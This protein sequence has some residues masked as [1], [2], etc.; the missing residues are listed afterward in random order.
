[1]LPVPILPFVGN[2]LIA[3]SGLA[4][5]TSH[6]QIH[7]DFTTSKST[8]ISL[9]TPWPWPSPNAC[10]KQPDIGPV[11]GGE[12]SSLVRSLCE[13]PPSLWR[14]GL[15]RTSPHT[16]GPS[17]CGTTG[18]PGQTSHWK[19]EV[20]QLHFTWKFTWEWS[21]MHWVI[22]LVKFKDCFKCIKSMLTLPAS[23]AHCSS[24][25]PCVWCQWSLWCTTQALSFPLHTHTH[26]NDK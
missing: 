3:F 23:H 17:L 12:D 13:L 25:S 4:V 11:L 20:L 18:T 16:P 2:S 7:N 14:F 1:M 19:Y 24:R 21:E 6:H 9:T 8:P 5:E 26:K 10:Q 22:H 15:G